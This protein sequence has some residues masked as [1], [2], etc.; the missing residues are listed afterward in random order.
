MG[1][2]QQKKVVKW[3]VQEGLGRI[4]VLAGG[5]GEAFSCGTT[6]VTHGWHQND[7][8]PSGGIPNT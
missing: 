3:S 6:V 5:K 8:V 1:E 2:K 4:E 7:Q